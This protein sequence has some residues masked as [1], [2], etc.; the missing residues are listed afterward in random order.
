MWNYYWSKLLFTYRVC[1]A[2]AYALNGSTF[3]LLRSSPL[4]L[5]ATLKWSSYSCR[6]SL[7]MIGLLSTRT[8]PMVFKLINRINTRISFKGTRTA[9]GCRCRQPSIKS[10]Y[11]GW[12]R[13]SR[14][15][16]AIKRHGCL[17]FVFSTLRTIRNKPKLSRYPVL[18]KLISKI[19][20]PLIKR[21][22]FSQRVFCLGTLLPLKPAHLIT[23]LSMTIS[24]LQQSKLIL[25]RCG[26]YLQAIK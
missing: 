20:Q 18:R 7:S 16:M 25:S 5:W 13:Y 2:T 24:R 22:I 12:L 21:F 1:Q 23:G 11:T 10:P 26:S 9:D 6:M 19:L 17:Q 4:S 3:S 15:L 8:H 14:E